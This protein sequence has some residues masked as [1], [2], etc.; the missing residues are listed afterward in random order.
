MCDDEFGPPLLKSEIGLRHFAICNL[1]AAPEKASLSSATEEE[2][3]ETKACLNLELRHTEG[4]H[5][6]VVGQRCG[7]RPKQVERTFVHAALI[8]R[9]QPAIAAVAKLQGNL[10][11]LLEVEVELTAG[12]PLSL[13]FG[14][15]DYGEGDLLPVGDFKNPDLGILV[16]N[17]HRELPLIRFGGRPLQ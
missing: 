2:A 9:A 13:A 5:A 8:A 10:L 15:P 12:E 4:I 3:R 16:F 6:A 14:V 7:Q 11:C 17:D 1:R